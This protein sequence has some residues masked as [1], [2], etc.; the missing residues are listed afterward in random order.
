M[1]RDGLI[2]WRQHD[3]FAAL[4]AHRRRRADEIEESIRTA[5]ATPLTLRQFD[6][7]DDAV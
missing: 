1:L 5:A 6:A 3:P 2:V 7:P 4:A